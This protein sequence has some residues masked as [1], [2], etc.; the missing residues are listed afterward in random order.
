MLQS[1]SR[2]VAAPSSSLSLQVA[3]TAGRTAWQA[4]SGRAGGTVWH[5]RGWRP[6][7]EPH[8]GPRGAR[9]EGEGA[10]TVKF[11]PDTLGER[12]PARTSRHV[13]R[14]TDIRWTLRVCS[15]PEPKS[16]GRRL[17]KTRGELAPLVPY[18]LRDARPGPAVPPRYTPDPRTAASLPTL[19]LEAR[20]SRRPVGKAS[21]QA[22]EGR[23]RGGAACSAK[24]IYRVGR[25]DIP[26]LMGQGVTRFGGTGGTRMVE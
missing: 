12:G 25:P 11:K 4:D 7:T 26:L 19:P 16:E 21:A 5:L 8:I 20:R 9:G 15:A 1:G 17:E 6:P 23:T 2:T 10:L 13:R 3:S 24:G 14:A 22:V 18:P